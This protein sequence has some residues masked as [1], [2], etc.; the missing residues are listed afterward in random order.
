[1]RECLIRT[2][3]VRGKLYSVTHVCGRFIRGAARDRNRVIDISIN[4]FHHGIGRRHN[5]SISVY[6]ISVDFPVRELLSFRSF[7]GGERYGFAEFCGFFI[8]GAARDRDI[9]FCIGIHRFHHGVCRSH[10]ERIAVDFLAVNRPVRKHFA[11]GDI[12]DS[13][14]YF[15]PELRRSFIRS[16]ARNRYG[17][18]DFPEYGFC[19]YVLCGHLKRIAFDLG[20]VNGPM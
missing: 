20:T 8:R 6:T 9:V 4:R 3:S 1:M 2:G 10:G 16:A 7:A 5:E 18:I 13:Q 19:R 12:T 17:I 15:I 11:F 14:R